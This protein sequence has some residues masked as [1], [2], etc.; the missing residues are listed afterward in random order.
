MI[1]WFILA[2]MVVAFDQMTKAI[3]QER[4]TLG[5]GE[6]ITDYF[7]IVL[8]HNPG[9]AFSFLQNAGGWQRWFLT[10]VALAACGLIISLLR[11]YSYNRM[12]CSGL[13]LILGG[14]IGN[15]IDRISR[16]YV[17]DF[18]DFH[19]R[20]FWAFFDSGHF[21]AFN[22]ADSAITVGAILI[23]LSELGRRRWGR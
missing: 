15:L 17:I 2:A 1:S 5:S 6:R 12:F 10:F 23:I 3:V 7:N 8:I 19:G 14:A 22:V 21:P 20:F 4:Y 13:S 16:G 9:A 18:L 11:A